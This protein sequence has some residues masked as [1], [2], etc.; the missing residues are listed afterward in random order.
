MSRFTNNSV[1]VF[2]NCPFDKIYYPKMHAMMFSIIRCGFV[3]RCALEESDSSTVRIN[4]IID[5]IL[6][7]SLGIHDISRTSLDKK[8]K[9]PRFNMPLE[10][11]L[12]LGAKRFGNGDQKKKKCLIFDIA[13]YR[14][15]Q[16]ISDIAGQDIKPHFDREEKLIEETRNFLKFHTVS[17][18]PSGRKI[19]I[20]YKV[21]CR[22]LPSICKGMKL[23]ENTLTFGERRDLM[24]AFIAGAPG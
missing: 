20:Q 12:F 2:I 17:N 23:H 4:K 21:F 5:I 3:P 14:Y 6:E 16:F 1:G 8:N 15:Q 24:T 10:L 13:P 7:C 9:L 19:F 22:K 18:L 11:G